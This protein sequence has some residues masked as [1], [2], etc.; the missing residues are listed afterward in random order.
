[1][2]GAEDFVDHSSPR[3]SSSHRPF[4]PL[5][6]AG[7]EYYRSPG[8]GRRPVCLPNLRYHGYLCK[9]PMCWEVVEFKAPLEVPSY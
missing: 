2:L 6:N 8:S 9:L 3:D 4:K 7:E 5:S 1:M